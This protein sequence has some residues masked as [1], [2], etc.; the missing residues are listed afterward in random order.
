M[1]RR[2][3]NLFFDSLNGNLV[4]SCMA[5]IKPLTNFAEEF[6]PVPTAVPP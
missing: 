3:S 5:L 4:I 6:N 1:T 2:D